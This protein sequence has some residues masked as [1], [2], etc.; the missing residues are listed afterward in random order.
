MTSTC[1]VF[2]LLLCGFFSGEKKGGW[3]GGSES[4]ERGKGDSHR[5][6][7]FGKR[8]GGVEGVQAG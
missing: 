4:V 5:D 6:D 7:F 3:V 8:G 1:T 2:F